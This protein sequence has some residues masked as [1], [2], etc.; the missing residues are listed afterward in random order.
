MSINTVGFQAYANA[1]QKFNQTE[2][3]IKS[4]GN[5]DTSLF[6]RTLDQTLLRDS[7]DKGEGFGAHPDFMKSRVNPGIPTGNSNSFTDTV[8]QSLSRVQA[9]ETEKGTAIQDFASGR[10]Q[11]VHELMITLQKASV[12]M[13]LTSAVRGKVL[14]AYRE[15]SKMQF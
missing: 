8:K 5:M 10:T 3:S 9:L 14:D 12:A 2:S 7:V 15:L 6:A 13:R 1:V 11:N 4:Y